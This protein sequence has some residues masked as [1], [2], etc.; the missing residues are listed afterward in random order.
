[1]NSRPSLFPGS[2]PIP[3]IMLTN[4]L[5][6]TTPE[7]IQSTNSPAIPF[8]QHKSVPA[9]SVSSR[10]STSKDS[11]PLPPRSSSEEGVIIHPPPPLD[12]RLKDGS[13]FGAPV[14]F[15]KFARSAAHVPLSPSLWTRL[16]A[17]WPNFHLAPLNAR[18]RRT[19]ETFTSYLRWFHFCGLMLQRFSG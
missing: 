9:F 19:M 13:L 1:M 8:N 2:F 11:P 18:I 3:D 16:I 12:R 15:N 10:D 6:P 7:K 5:L 4:L 17:I 14:L